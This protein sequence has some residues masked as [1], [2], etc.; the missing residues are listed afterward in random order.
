VI[1]LTPRGDASVEALQLVDGDV[2]IF[3]NPGLAP[4]G[5]GWS[6]VSIGRHERQQRLDRNAA[7]G[8]LAYDMDGDGYLDVVSAARDDNNAQIAWF[9]N[10]GPPLLT[11][12]TWTQY[13][14]GSLRDAWSRDVADVTGDGSPDVIATGAAQMQTML[15]VHPGVAFPNDRF[16]YD[17]DSYVITTFQRRR[18]LLRTPRRSTE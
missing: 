9:R 3:V 18:A 17:W 15:F 14:L 10:P 5:E 11:E 2:V 6:Q 13:R 4:D 12:N 7:A 8:L 16:E 1:D